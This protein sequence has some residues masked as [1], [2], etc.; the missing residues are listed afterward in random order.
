MERDLNPESEDSL[1]L[2]ALLMED[3]QNPLLIAARSKS[4][5]KD[6]LVANECVLD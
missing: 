5:S 2:P 3:M 4:L 1:F 6:T